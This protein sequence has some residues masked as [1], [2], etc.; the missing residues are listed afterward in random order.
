MLANNQTRE[1]FLSMKQVRSFRVGKYN[2]AEESLQKKWK[3]IMLYLLPKFSH[4]LPKKISE[5]TTNY[6]Q[7][8]SEVTIS[9]EAFLFFILIQ[10]DKTEQDETDMSDLTPPE[11]E[12]QEESPSNN[13]QE[14]KKRKFTQ[15]SMKNTTSKKFKLFQTIFEEVKKNRNNSSDSISWDEALKEEADNI[16]GVAK[17]KSDGNKF[18]NLKLVLGQ[19]KVEE[20]IQDHCAYDPDE[21]DL[22]WGMRTKVE[23]VEE[24]KIQVEEV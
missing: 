1:P 6:S 3:Y 11:E 23:E 12:E 10:M 21:C 24:E 7:K 14:G 8:G 5:I 4:S 17:P 15:F 2:K 9:D 16:L 22:L 20:K 18:D 13:Q 19:K